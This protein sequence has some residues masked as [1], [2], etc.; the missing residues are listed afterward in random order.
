MNRQNQNDDEFKH[1]EI[2][3]IFLD[4]FLDIFYI[5]GELVL[6]NYLIKLTMLTMRMQTVINSRNLFD[7]LNLKG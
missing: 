4:I 7:H 6:I 2:K 3:N 5:Y 1:N